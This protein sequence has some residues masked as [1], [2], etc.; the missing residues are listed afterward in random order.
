MVQYKK[1]RKK[2]KK[3]KN[4]REKKCLSFC[5][6][7]S[8]YVPFIIF[9]QIKKI[10]PKVIKENEFG[11]GIFRDNHQKKIQDT[12]LNYQSVPS[13]YALCKIC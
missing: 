1:K 10:S 2:R 4:K 6:S 12:N 3:I 11:G 8:I 5:K 13:F 9:I 7:A